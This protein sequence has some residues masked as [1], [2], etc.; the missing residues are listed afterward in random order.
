VKIQFENVDFQSRSGPNGFGL[1]LARSLTQIG[2]SIVGENPDVRLTFINGSNTFRPNVLRLDGIYFNSEQDWQRMNAPI[3]ASYDFANAVIV[4]SEFNK[5]LT[6]K[7]FGVRDGIH[8]IHNGT[9]TSLI[10]KIPAAVLGGGI[11]R[12]NVWMCASAWR[13]HKRLSDN[14]RLFLELSGKDDVLLVAGKDAQNHT[15]SD[16]NDSRVKFIGDLDWES[17]IS[18]MKASSKFIHLSWLDHCPNVVVDANAC[19]CTVYCSS[20]GGTR[21]IAGKGAVVI[22]EDEW[23]MMPTLLYKPPMI[24]FT[25]QTSNLYSINPDIKDTAE[26]YRTILQYS[27]RKTNGNY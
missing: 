7:Y 25:R 8:V 1:K 21:E 27:A 6:E 16:L 13:P 15:G 2:H 23:D 10:E 17:M 24:D 26:K 5:R 3:R 11:P 19:G 14:I 12:E 9:D 4:Q 18:C 20:S 22:E